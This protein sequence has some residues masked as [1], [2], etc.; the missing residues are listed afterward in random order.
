MTATECMHYYGEMLMVNCQE[1]SGNLYKLAEGMNVGM[2][3][4]V[5][6]DDE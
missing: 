5:F 4:I 1:N 6:N 2:M 3:M